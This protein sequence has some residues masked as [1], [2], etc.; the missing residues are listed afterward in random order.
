MKV[1]AFNTSPRKDG[2]TALLIRQV[3]GVLHFV[4]NPN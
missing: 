1:I 4:C 3:F 2:N